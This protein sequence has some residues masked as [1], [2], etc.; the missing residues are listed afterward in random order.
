M[1]RE[2]ERETERQ[3]EML[4]VL[5]LWRTLSHTLLICSPWFSSM[6]INEELEK[7]AKTWI[8][9]HRIDLLK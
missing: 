2:R 9:Q 1:K 7:N 5:F 3:R 4:L 6:S 8:T